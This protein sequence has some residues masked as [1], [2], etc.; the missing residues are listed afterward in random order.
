[1]KSHQDKEN[2]TYS[3]I[4]VWMLYVSFFTIQISLL[5][6]LQ[7]LF[8]QIDFKNRGTLLDLCHFLLFF[9]P[10]MNTLLQAFEWISM[11]DIVEE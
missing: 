8:P 9:M 4:S 3:K 7:Q 5:L 6:C 2:T 11:S 1:L 10:L